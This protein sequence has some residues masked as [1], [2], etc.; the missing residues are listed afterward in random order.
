MC[1][2]M[3]PNMNSPLAS[4]LPC[5]RAAL[6]AV[7]DRGRIWDKEGCAKPAARGVP[8]GVWGAADLQHQQ[9]WGELHHG[10]PL[11]C[12]QPHGLHALRSPWMDQVS[13]F[14]LL[15]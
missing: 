11:P 13:S 3:E 12:K 8:G 14:A 5:A 4:V 15:S 7:S 9:P 1:S 10:T 2:C 6:C